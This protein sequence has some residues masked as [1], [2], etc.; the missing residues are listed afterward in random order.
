VQNL[1]GSRRKAAQKTVDFS[2]W[3]RYD[4]GEKSNTEDV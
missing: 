3:L 1:C 2:G 4:K